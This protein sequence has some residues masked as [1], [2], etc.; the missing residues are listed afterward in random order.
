VEPDAIVVRARRLEPGMVLA[1]EPSYRFGVIEKIEPYAG[2]TYVNITIGGETSGCPA[3]ALLT[4]IN[5][6]APNDASSE[7]RSE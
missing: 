4:I 1:D 2:G 6:D 7:R 5:P 3:A